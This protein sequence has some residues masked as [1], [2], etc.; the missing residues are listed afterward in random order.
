MVL[1]CL[2]DP[3]SANARGLRDVLLDGDAIVLLGT[4]VTLARHRHPAL[5][6]W[7]VR[8]VSLHALEEDLQLLGV[9]T[10]DPRVA[11]IDYSGWVELVA[12][13]PRQLV[14]R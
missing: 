10:A 13:L 2:Y 4:A 6:D 9:A 11:V 5:D 1:H 8:G 14:W 3:K 12:R 7:L